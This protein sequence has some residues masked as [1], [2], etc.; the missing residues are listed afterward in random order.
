MTNEQEKELEK[1]AKIRTLRYRISDRIAGIENINSS[2]VDD[3]LYEFQT[4]LQQ[5]L[6][7]DSVV[8]IEI[9]KIVDECV[10]ALE[11]QDSVAVANEE[12]HSELKNIVQRYILK[13]LQSKSDSAL[14]E[15]LAVR[16][17]SLEGVTFHINK[18]CEFAL[19]EFQHEQVTG[20]IARCSKIANE[21]LQF[22]EG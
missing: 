13:A 22:Q 2:I 19:T 10:E 18:N 12:E 14:V 11:Y 15:E 20:S 7:S 5:I 3:I 21:L 8:N 16:L 1:S 9:D 6:S 4:E 17:N